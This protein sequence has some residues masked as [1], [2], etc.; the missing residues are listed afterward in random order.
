MKLS[1]DRKIFC[2]LLLWSAVVLMLMSPD[3]PIHGVWNRCDSAWFFMGGKAMMNGLRPYVDFCDSKGPLLWFIYGI[4]YL[5][6]PRSYTGVWVLTVFFYAGIFYYNFKTARIFLKDNRR[7]LM[8][9]LLMAVPYFI[10]WFHY[11]I[12]AEDF[13]TL[14][15]AVSLYYLF[16]LLYAKD[17][18]QHSIRLTGLVLGGC[19]M[20]LFLIKYNI[21]VM[22]AFMIL[23]ALYYYVRETDKFWEPMK[24]L[25]AGAFAVALPFVLYLLLMGVFDAFFTEYLFKTFLTKHGSE[26]AFSVD[27]ENAMY[28]PPIFSL[29]IMIVFGGW[30]IGRKLP[31]YRYV[32][33]LTVIVFFVLSSYRCCFIYYY[34]TCLIFM[35]FIFVVILQNASL[36]VS[37]RSLGVAVL[38]VLAWCVYENSH[39]KSMLYKSAIWTES[40]SREVYQDVARLF[41]TVPHPR[42][43]NL[44]SNEQ[45]LGIEAEPLPAGK[46]WSNQWGATEEMVREHVDL[47]KSGVADFVVIFV[48]GSLYEHGMTWD[49]LESYGYRKCYSREYG[50]FNSGV[51][52]TT[53]VCSKKHDN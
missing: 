3:S 21:A 23:V 49:D 16:H 22:Q 5:L 17:E 11:E 53:V 29:F 37:K 38:I 27:V 18:P 43:I 35:L 32:P 4:G 30:L 40:D 14:P 2:W 7:S 50:H 39:P 6:S 47:L 1:V 9:T 42:I 26:Y 48:E 34:V 45:G 44:F 25:S 33:L 15:V 24:W 12:R 13:C 31:R 41:S 46:Y 19:F 28:D 10:Y 51:G 8:A 20:A 52:I 36:S